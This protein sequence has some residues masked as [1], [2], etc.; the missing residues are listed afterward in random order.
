MYRSILIYTFLIGGQLPLWAQNNGVQ[1]LL[2]PSESF[3]PQRLHTVI[4]SEVVLTSTVALALN[5]LWYRK[6]PHSC[7]HF[8]NDNDEWLNMDKLGHA[9]TAYNVAAVQNDLMRSSGL[10]TRQSS[11]IG[12]LTGL[13][14]LTIVEVFDG[15][16]QK[17]GFSKGDMLANLAGSA[18]FVMQQALWKRQKMALRFSYH[19]SIYSKY[20]P[21]ELGRNFFERWIKDYNGQTYWL[22]F[23]ASS[24]LPSSTRIPRWANVDIGYSAEGMIGARSNP[25]SINE[26]KI[27]EFNRFRKLYFSIDA[28]FKNNDTNVYPGWPNILKVPSPVLE[29]KLNGSRPR[30]IP[31]Y[32]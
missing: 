4:L 30:L 15:I 6:F 21:D 20:N 8:F 3:N 17:W 10:N 14:M 5:Y 24:F 32:F 7:F 18:L 2:N 9:T 16:S 13:G 29:W 22:S 31:L 1:G 12:A 23:N 26:I 28:V 27:P 19:N 25:S 11:L